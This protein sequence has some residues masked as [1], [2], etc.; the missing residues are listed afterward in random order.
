MML[1]YRQIPVGTGC[2]VLL[3]TN[4]GIHTQVSTPS[5]IHTYI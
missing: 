3:M 5:Y 2:P 4:E 1:V